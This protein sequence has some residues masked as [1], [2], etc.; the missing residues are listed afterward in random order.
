[1]LNAVAMRMLTPLVLLVATLILE[2]FFANE[3]D[4]AG[5]FAAAVEFTATVS[6]SVA[7]IWLFWLT[8]QLVLQRLFS[9]RA[10]MRRA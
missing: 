3:I 9:R 5:V 2:P 4:T 10:S 6:R 1:M 7:A 8:N